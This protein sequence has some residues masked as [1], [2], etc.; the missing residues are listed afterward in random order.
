MTFNQMMI[1][2]SAPTLC[3]IKCGNMFFTKSKEFN[4]YYFDNWKKTFYEMGF[5][6]FSLKLSDETTAILVLNLSWINKIL[7]QNLA[8]KYLEKKHYSSTNTSNFLNELFSRMIEN[9][10]FPHEVGIILGYPVEDVIEFE[11]NQGHN[12]KY[13]GYW[14]SYSDVEKA[15]AC[16]N[17]Y[18]DCS[19]KCRF[20]YDQGY[21][22]FQIINTYKKEQKAA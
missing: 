2:F 14:K 12:C 19:I 21:S 20:L 6:T 9:P 1:Q 18:K 7:N 10:D 8:K 16:Q 15:K 11:K 22:L 5:S 13:C 17:K 4:K 3:N